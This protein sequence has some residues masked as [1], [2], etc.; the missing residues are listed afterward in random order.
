VKLS[1][2]TSDCLHGPWSWTKTRLVKVGLLL[3][4]TRDAA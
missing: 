2:L 4:T 1:G 3:T